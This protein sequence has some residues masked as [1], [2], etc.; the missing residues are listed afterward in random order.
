MKDALKDIVKHT[1]GLGGIDLVKITGTNDETIISAIAEDKSVIVEAKLH[2]PIPEFTGLFGMPNLAKLKFILDIPEYAEHAD[3]KLAR[4]KDPEGN[5]VPSGLEFSN[6][7]GD[8]RNNFRF[9]LAH[10][11]TEKLKTVKFRG[12]NWDVELEPSVNSITRFK[13]QSQ[14]HSEET[15][16]IAKTEAN[17][18]EFHFG[19]ASSHAGNFVFASGVSG[20]LTAERMWPVSVFASIFALSGDKVMR[21]SDQGAAQITVDSGMAQYTY[22]IP[23]LQK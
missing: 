20:K 10:I 12:A 21:F 19:D 8:F 22:T 4:Q 1:H 9:M 7:V 5:T 23:A 17:N 11:I 14:A 2:V 3:I 6:K 16:F 13:F 18:L 15:S